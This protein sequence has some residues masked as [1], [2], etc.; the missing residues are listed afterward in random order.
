MTPVLR[1]W[2]VLPARERQLLVELGR[3]RLARTEQLAR[4]VCS[5]TSPAIEMRLV[6]RHLYRLRRDGLV[7]RFTNRARDRRAGAPGHLYTL[8]ASGV[9]VLGNA[10]GIA[11]HQRRNY[12]PSDAFLDHRLAITE[13]YVRLVEHA[14]DGG[15]IVREFTAEP[16]CWRRYPGP[17]GQPLWLKPDA[18]VRLGVRRGQGHVELS[19]FIEIDRDTEGRSTIAAK[20]TSYLAYESTGIE[21]RQH[22]VFP[23][24]LFV[25]PS[26]ARAGAL[27]RLVDHLPPS[28]RSLFA[29]TT[30]DTALA[31]LSQTVP[32]SPPDAAS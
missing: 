14:R 6:R 9:R 3:I 13:L 23:A 12:Q 20:C 27:G 8:T 1:S 16:D 29:V 15:P 31:A 7:R 28:S 26:T 10:R 19:W 30:A 21:Q 17:A 2:S 25:V 32:S 24:V 4:L 18:L 22:S 5:A 11:T